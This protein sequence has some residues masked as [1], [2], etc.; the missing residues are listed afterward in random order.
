M[1]DLNVKLI[2]KTSPGIP[3]RQ[4][5]QDE[6]VAKVFRQSLNEILKTY[7]TAV[8]RGMA[9]ELGVPM[10]VIRPRVKVKHARA[11][12]IRRGRISARIWVG[13]YRMPLVKTLKV[14]SYVRRGRHGLVTGTRTRDRQKLARGSFL[15]RM[16]NGHVGLFIRKAAARYAT[17]MDSKGRPRK[18]RLPIEELMV[19][20]GP[21][22]EKVLMELVEDGRFFEEVERRF[23]RKLQQYFDG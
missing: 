3:L 22:A 18:N 8:V 15:Q 6:L 20:I 12:D 5:A 10:K 2:Q 4:L 13:T 17:G 23:W 19:N 11:A 21:A 7:R 9:R 1:I 14:G 16:P